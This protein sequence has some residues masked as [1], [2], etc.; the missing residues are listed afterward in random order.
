M[1]EPTPRRRLLG[2]ALIGIGALALPLT[3]SISYAANDAPAAPV[4]PTTAAAPHKESRIT[5]IEHRGDSPADESK[6]QTRVITRDGKTIMFKTDKP[7]TDAEIEQHL[8]RAEAQMP[9]PPVPP[10]DPVAPGH[11]INTRKII[12][13]NHGSQGAGG[14]QG[15]GHRDGHAM[16]F[17]SADSGP[18]CADGDEASN[19]DVSEDKAGKAQVIK[20]RFCGEG[21]AKAQA[22]NAIREARANISADTDISADVRAKVLK[23]LDAEIERLSKEG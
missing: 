10:V 8:A 13:L 21:G 17:A 4:P 3:A 2:R 6:L 15:A 1:N 22:L 11:R 18:A 23:Q 19:I 9:M 12:V 16:A 7:L 14:D 5:I 20:L